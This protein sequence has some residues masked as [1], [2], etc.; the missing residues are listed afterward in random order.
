MNITIELTASP[1]LLEA[2]NN[3]TAAF[4]GRGTNLTDLSPVKK[5]ETA[6]PVIESIATDV[7]LADQPA[8][9][10]PAQAEHKT[11]RRRNGR[12]A[13]EAATD[14]PATAS[15]GPTGTTTSDDPTGEPVTI[16]M[17]RAAVRAKTIDEGK[18]EEAVDLLKSFGSPNVT[19]LDPSKYSKFLEKLKA[20]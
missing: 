12:T 10:Q 1:A 17:V 5:P 11:T 9:E 4:A 7:K 18:R 19:N 15:E 14:V 16:E 8:A 2:I 3:L 6:A 20:L 13:T